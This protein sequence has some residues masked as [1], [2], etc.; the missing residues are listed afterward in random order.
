METTSGI[1]ILHRKIEDKHYSIQDT[2]VYNEYYNV[3]KS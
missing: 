2:I 1:D 3:N